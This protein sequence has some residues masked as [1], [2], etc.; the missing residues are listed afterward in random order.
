MLVRPLLTETKANL[1]SLCETAGVSWRSDPTNLDPSTVRGRLRRDVLPVLEELWP[2][3]AP[4]V[5][6]NADIV[7]AAADAL[8]LSFMSAASYLDAGAPSAASSS[9]GEHPQRLLLNADIVS[10]SK[11]TR[12]EALLLLMCAYAICSLDRLNIS[13][14]Q[15]Q[16]ISSRAG[17]GRPSGASA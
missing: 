14:A 6:A 4:R 8:V 15:L 3:V 11:A 5:A 7:R 12:R 2:K 17:E 1:L 16:I 9:S 10:Q 13:T